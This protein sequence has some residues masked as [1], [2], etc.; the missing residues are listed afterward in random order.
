[1]KQLCVILEK[2]NKV[3]IFFGSFDECYIHDFVIFITKYAIGMH[4]GN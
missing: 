4:L 1:M 3:N 2:G